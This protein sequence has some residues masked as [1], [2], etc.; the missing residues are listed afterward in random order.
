GGGRHEIGFHRGLSASAEKGKVAGKPLPEFKIKTSFHDGILAILKTVPPAPSAAPARELPRFRFPSLRLPR[1]TWKTP[2]P[3]RRGLKWAGIALLIL[4]PLLYLAGEAGFSFYQLNR[5]R[6][7]FL[8]LNFP[9]AQA[10]TAAASSSLGRLSKLLPAVRSLVEISQAAQEVS[11]QGT[12]LTQALE[13]LIKSRR[14]E[15]I[16]P[17]DPQDFQAAQAA[18]S[19][20]EQHLTLAWLEA[21][22][23]EAGF[24]RQPT[25]ELQGTLGE[26]IRVLRVA[27]AFLGQ[28]EELLGYRGERTYLLLF[29]N[30]TELR[31]T[32]GFFGSFAQLT[33][34]NGGVKKLEFFDSYQFQNAGKVPYHIAVRQLLR[35]DETPLYDTNIHPSFPTAAQEIAALFSQAQGIPVHA[36]L[37]TTLIFTQDLLKVTGSLELVEFNRT[38]DAENLFEVATE[39]AEKEFF[40]GTTKKKRLLQA[41]GEGLVERIFAAS[42]SSYPRLARAVWSSL[43]QRNLLL[44]FTQGEVAQA[45]AEAGWD[46]GISAASSDYL[47]VFDNNYSA[48][49]NDVFVKRSLSYRVYSPDKS[50]AARGEL[51]VT[52]NHTGTNSWPSNTYQN[53]VLILT[54]KGSKLMGAFLNGADFYGTYPYEEED[55][56]G[57]AAL[58]FIPHQATT[59]FKII[60]ELP[61]GF[62][63]T[64]LE[65]YRLTVQ[66]Q[67]G[68]TGDPFTFSFEP[69]IGKEATGSD[70]QKKGNGLIFEGSLT[71][72]L[73]LKIEIKER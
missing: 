39:E 4:S 57:F 29:Q 7:A 55:K 16:A 9:R 47:G 68:T 58:F 46:G 51:T 49:V 30:S 25:K 5:A 48:K 71:T 23:I 3:T 15:E 11:E 19:A 40:P 53:L 10:A 35:A 62:D 41:L 52:W 26:G 1:L 24:L 65:N 33:L 56:S 13:N 22:Q 67:P 45:L 36:V 32:G 20:A 59:T 8:S 18:F 38:V 61:K 28:A 14:G 50:G 69:T 60:Y 17:Q 64:T 63:F 34:E 73:E 2:R 72:D 66:K 54:P 31:S 70:L 42:S 43:N 27:A 44:Y 37:G 21:Q 6:S 12:V